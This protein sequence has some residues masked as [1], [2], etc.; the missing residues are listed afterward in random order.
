MAFEEFLEQFGLSQYEK[1]AYTTLLRIGRSKSQEIAK[2]S[3]VSYGRIYEILEKLT[4]KGLITLFPT[5]PKTFEAIDPKLA[6]KLIIKQKEDHLHELKKQIEVLSI[7]EQHIKLL[8]QDQTIVLQG[9]QKQLSMISEMHERAKKEILLIPGVYE[10]NTS[11]KTGT[12]KA[13][14]R[15]VKINLLVTEITQHNK[16]FIKEGMKLGQEVRQNKL[17]GLRLIVADNKEAMI[18]IVNP[19]TKDRISIYTT[20]KEFAHSMGIF[21][22]ALWIGS[23]QIKMK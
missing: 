10:L 7:P 22:N 16:E 6:F 17:S 18:S 20:N 12:I 13:L 3:N 8:T 2:E 5:E 4:D 14:T 11:R 9:K 23:K 19:A 1:M 21:F 15:G